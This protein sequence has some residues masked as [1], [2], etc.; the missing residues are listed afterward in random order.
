MDPVLL[1]VIEDAA[2][3]RHMTEE[4]ASRFARDYT[5]ES[6]TSA[7]SAID[8]LERLRAESHAVAM[9]LADLSM[10]STDAI[11]FLALVRRIVPTAARILV[12]DR[13]VGNTAADAVRRAVVLGR[14]DSALTM[15]S[16]R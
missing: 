14:I 5:L 8:R 4:L 15:P 7:T 3:R 6:S 12:H 10:S 11:A 9:V 16:G 13:A 2:S 1:L